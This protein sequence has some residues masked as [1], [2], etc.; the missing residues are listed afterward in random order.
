MDNASISESEINNYSSLSDNIMAGMRC[1]TFAKVIQ[2]Y[3]EKTDKRWAH[4]IDAQ[5]IVKERIR[6]LKDGEEYDKY[7]EL[8]PILNIPYLRG[9]GEPNVGDYCVLLHLDRP[10][11]NI[12]TKGGADSPFIESSGNMHELGNCVAICGF[13]GD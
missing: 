13:L 12:S 7:I 8:P 5:P 11:Y 3:R 4:T 10:I 9:L 2:V 1:H 6:A